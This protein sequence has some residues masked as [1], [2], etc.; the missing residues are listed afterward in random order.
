MEWEGLMGKHQRLSDSGP[1]IEVE[2]VG[3]VYQPSPPMMRL[4]LRSSIRSPVVALD[5]VT[6]SVQAG[7][8]CAVIGPNGAGKSSL[9]R[10]LTGLTTPTTGSARVCGFDVTHQSF[11]VRKRVGFAPPGEQSLLL[12]N[13]CRENLLF[14]GQLQGIPGRALRRRVAKVLELV[15]LEDA[16]DRVAVALSSGMKA[17]LQLARAI[18]HRPP[19]LLLDEPTSSVDPIGAFE[20]LDVIER[21]VKEENSAALV[22]SHRMDE[23]EALHDDVVLLDQGRVRYLGDLDGLRRLWEEPRL[24][25]EFGSPSAARAAASLLATLDGVAVLARADKN[26][27][28]NTA[29]EIGMLLSMTNGRLGEVRSVHRPRMPLRELLARVLADDGRRS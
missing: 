1:F 26:V 20:I 9:F 5:D 27:V 29:L 28:L 6:L 25:I 3:K 12:R 2:Q 10:I 21:I 19:V 23:T 13:T 24:E 11:E 7:K 4:L 16:A 14:H 17:R 18:L 8:I 22:S 15:G